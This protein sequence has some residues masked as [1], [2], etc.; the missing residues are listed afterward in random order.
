MRVDGCVPRGAREI[1]TLQENA[2]YDYLGIKKKV[3]QVKYL[4]IR[5][6]PPRSRVLKLLSQPEVDNVAYM[7]AATRANEEIVRLHITMNVAS[8]VHVFQAM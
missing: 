4:K 3:L 2:P 5:N 7:L 1:L 6:M 8:A